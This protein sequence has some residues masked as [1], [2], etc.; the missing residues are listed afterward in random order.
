MIWYL[1]SVYLIQTFLGSAEGYPCE[2]QVILYAGKPLS[3]NVKL[4][5][6]DD[7]ATLDCEIRMLGGEALVD[8]PTGFEITAG[9]QL[10]GRFNY[11]IV[12]GNARLLGV[13]FLRTVRYCRN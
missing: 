12:I 7:L 8:S 2:E 11:Y 4:I 9:K 5:S 1:N 13:K 10:F 3:D 6:F